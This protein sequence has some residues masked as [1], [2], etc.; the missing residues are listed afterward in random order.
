MDTHSWWLSVCMLLYYT[1]AFSYSGEFYT[2]QLVAKINFCSVEY[3]SADNYQGLMSTSN[4][5]MMEMK[6]RMFYSCMGM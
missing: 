4:I 3:S 5:L 1:L 6:S 2:S